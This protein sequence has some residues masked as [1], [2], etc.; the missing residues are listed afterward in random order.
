M[1]VHYCEVDL[2]LTCYFFTVK[3]LRAELS[4]CSLLLQELTE[5]V[6]GQDQELKDVRKEVALLLSEL[7]QTKNILSVISKE[8]SSQK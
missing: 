1:L 5:R 8:L 4:G 7:G 2:L 6:K 3:H